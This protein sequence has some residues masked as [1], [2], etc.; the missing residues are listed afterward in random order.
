MSLDGFERVNPR[1]RLRESGRTV[2][3]T[4]RLREAISFV[5]VSDVRGSD[6][7]TS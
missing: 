2:N 5:I 3:G 7:D 1:A 6:S 4:A